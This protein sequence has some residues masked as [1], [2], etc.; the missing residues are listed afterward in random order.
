M[1]AKNRIQVSLTE[2]HADLINSIEKNYRLKASEFIRLAIDYAVDANTDLELWAAKERL[3]RIDKDHARVQ[4]RIE[5]LIAA[6]PT[7]ARSDTQF[8][9]PGSRNMGIS[10]PAEVRIADTNHLG[11]TEQEKGTF[12]RLAKLIA[13]KD[14]GPKAK[15]WFLEHAK[16]YPEWV[17][18]ALLP[19]QLPAIEKELGC[20]LRAISELK[21]DGH[22][23]SIE[24]DAK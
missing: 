17:E 21:S 3:K 1:P 14:A 13:E 7:A 16:Q 4:S 19:G 9:L 24:E 23:S 12:Q 6:R 2:A 18:D 15:T 5:E 10:R 8:E 11:G 22:E 20:T